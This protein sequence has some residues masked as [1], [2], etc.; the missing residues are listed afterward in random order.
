MAKT[1]Q[2]SIVT[3][4]NA[5][6]PVNGPTTKENEREG[7][8]SPSALK[9]IYKYICALGVGECVLSVSVVQWATS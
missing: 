7:R 6:A 2:C 3:E 1:W 9:V 5:L 4:A 8:F